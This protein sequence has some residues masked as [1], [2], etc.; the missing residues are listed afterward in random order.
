[1]SITL[2]WAGGKHEFLVS[3]KV[4]RQLQT[5]RDISPIGLLNRLRTDDWYVDDILDVLVFALSDAGMNFEQ[6]NSL[7][8][9]MWA[10]HGPME[11]LPTA[12]SV[13]ISGLVGD[14]DDP[15]GKSKAA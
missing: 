15:L 10:K 14:M 5:S 6:A 11:I 12:Q 7:V 13:M 2:N 9:D 4:L 1:M 8:Q 3:I